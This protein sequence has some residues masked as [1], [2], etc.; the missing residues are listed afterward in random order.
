MERTKVQKWKVVG[1]GFF[2]ATINGTKRII[3]PGQ[4]FDA[5]LEDI[6]EGFRDVITPVTEDAES[7]IQHPVQPKV[8][9]KT[10]EPEVMEEP[11][12]PKYFVQS[13]GAGYY[14]VV[15]VNG[16]VMNEKALRKDAADE[17]LASLQ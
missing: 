17:L 9:P 13:R 2:Y 15:D 4:I 5:R 12:N 7:L 11:V 3:K 8:E 10:A 14:N 16:K 1:G 6:P